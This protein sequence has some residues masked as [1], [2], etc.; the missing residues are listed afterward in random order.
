MKKLLL[1]VLLGVV[2][3]GLPG[4]GADDSPNYGALKITDGP[5][6]EFAPCKVVTRLGNSSSTTFSCDRGGGQ[7][8]SLIVGIQLPYQYVIYKFEGASDPNRN[9]EFSASCDRTA[10]SG[11]RTCR[12][13]GD[14][15]LG[16]AL[17]TPSPKTVRFDNVRLKS[18]KS[19]S[20]K[21][22][23][24]NGTLKEE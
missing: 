10:T 8:E 16:I 14:F 24:L 19:V 17:S 15:P 20:G 4:C 21:D 3:V 9:Y 2:C 11:S 5:V 13:T 12:E 7:T 6:S 18:D 1:H 23:F 22:I